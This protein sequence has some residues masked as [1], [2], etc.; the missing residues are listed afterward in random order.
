GGLQGP[1]ENVWCGVRPVPRESPDQF[2]NPGAISSP[3]GASRSRRGDHVRPDAEAAARF[4]KAA[5][6]VVA[7]AALAYGVVQVR[8]LA[9][10]RLA[11]PPREVVARNGL[12][13]GQTR[14]A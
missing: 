12:E 14:S 5:Q 7:V 11:G 8:A 6:V 9:S 3:S 10:A 1:R 2:T 13:A 4:P